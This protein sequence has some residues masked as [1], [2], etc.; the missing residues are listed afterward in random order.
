MKELMEYPIYN[1]NL[2]SQLKVT[3]NVKKDKIVVDNK[4]MMW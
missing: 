1:S 4:K 2:I 3:K